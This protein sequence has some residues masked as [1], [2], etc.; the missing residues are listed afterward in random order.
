MNQFYEYTGVS[1][2]DSSY[3]TLLDKEN[4]KNFPP[5]YIATCEFDPLRDDGK[6]L[7]KTLKAAGVSVKEDYWE[8]LPHVSFPSFRLA[9]SYS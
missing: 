2:T 6:L 8:G 1:P 3:F 7:G 5:T 4:L 9:Q